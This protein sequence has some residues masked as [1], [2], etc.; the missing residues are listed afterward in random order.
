MQN[1][2]LV[3]PSSSANA[4]LAYLKPLTFTS[5]AH[6]LLT[7]DKIAIYQFEG[8]IN[9]NSVFSVTVINPN[10]F[11]IPV[12]ALGE[13]GPSILKYYILKNKLECNFTV[14]CI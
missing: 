7:G 4:T 5:A 12:N 6:G 8:S 3:F 2:P 14:Y 1:L 11:T 13:T 9:I 10:T